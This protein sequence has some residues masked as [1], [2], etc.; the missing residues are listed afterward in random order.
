MNA[1]RVLPMVMFLAI[2]F[3]TV[4]LIK[5]TQIIKNRPAQWMAGFFTAEVATFLLPSV[6]DSFLWYDSAATGY[7]S[8]VLTLLIINICLVFIKKRPNLLLE[9]PFYLIVALSAT[10]SE[11][12]TMFAIGGFGLI[13]IIALFRKQKSIYRYTIPFCIALIIGFAVLYFSPGSIERRATAMPTAFS[14]HWVFF[15][16]IKDIA[17]N[18]LGHTAI[19]ELGLLI[20]YCIFIASQAELTGFWKKHPKLLLLI[21]VISLVTLTYGTIVIN[22]IAQDYIPYRIYTLPTFGAVFS[23]AIIAIGLKYIFNYSFFKNPSSLVTTISSVCIIGVLL[24][25]LLGTGNY[26]SKLSLRRQLVNYRDV[27][28]KQQILDGNDTIYL[29]E[30]PSLV[31]GNAEDIYY[32][33]TEDE[34]QK[35]IWVGLNYANYMGATDQ[36]L[37]LVAAPEMYYY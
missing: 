27:Y 30:A 18:A 37:V 24:L 32:Y 36:N 13:S 15:E 9:L 21:G 17:R 1:V 28:T 8:I 29:I 6:F 26:I 16:S 33:W 7:M 25:T 2:G 3:L 11:P 5:N 20:I 4:W 22:N 31:L 14:I 19:W 35:I 12:T 34:E 10:F 23:L